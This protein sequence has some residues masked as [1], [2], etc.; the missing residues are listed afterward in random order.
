MYNE[1]NSTGYILE[2]KEYRGKFRGSR[3]SE[4]KGVG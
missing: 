4:E 3:G 1:Y 2:C